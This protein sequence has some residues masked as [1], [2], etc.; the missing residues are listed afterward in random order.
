MDLSFVK[1][2]LEANANKSAGREKIDYTKIFWKP[3][4]GKYQIRIVPNKFRKEWPLREIQMH[5]GFSKGPILS[6]TNWK[7]P[8]PIVEFAQKLRK[9]SDKEDWTLANKVSPKTRYFAPVVVRGE[10][11]L[12]VRLW[13]V[14]KLVNDQLLGIAN[15]E[16]YGEFDDI[17]EGR[18]FTVEATSAIVAGKNGIS[19]TIRPKP[20]TSPISDDASFVKK[21]LDEQPDILAINRKYTF[22]QLKDVLQKWLNPE[23]ETEETAAPLSSN[24]EED[25]EESN[26]LF[27]TYKP[28]AKVSNKDKFDA[29]FSDDDNDNDNDLPF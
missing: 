22:D 17:N 20:K 10:E 24:N 3:K 25:T 16:D 19:C 26:D 21:A 5:Y 18:D 12:G 27:N 1:Q 8:D 4:P 28:E 23:E 14:G 11:N 7:E 6:L 15:D 29:L 2:K 9:S 13:E